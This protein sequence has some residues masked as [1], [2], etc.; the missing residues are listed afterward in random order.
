MPPARA[1]AVPSDR[2]SWGKYVSS[3]R[4]GKVVALQKRLKPMVEWK[5][6]SGMSKHRGAHRSSVV[7]VLAVLFIVPASLNGQSSRDLPSRVDS[8]FSAWSGTDRP[9]C[10]VGV[11]QRG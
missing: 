11:S 6:L 4:W 8:L 3:F 9:G 1:T 2:R 10:A 5:C 7:Y